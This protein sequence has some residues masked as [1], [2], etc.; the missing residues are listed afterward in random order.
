MMDGKFLG[1]YTRWGTVD[2]VAASSRFTA[3]F[4][5]GATFEYIDL[6][7][8]GTTI[9]QVTNISVRING[10]EIQSFR[11]GTELELWNSFQDEDYTTVAG[12][13]RFDFRR[14]GT[15]N[16]ALRD[17]TMIGT[18]VAAQSAAQAVVSTFEISGDLASGITPTITPYASVRDAAPLGLLRLVRP[19]QFTPPAT[20]SYEWDGLP[21]SAVIE[22]IGHNM[23][24]GVFD[25]VKLKVNQNIISEGPITRH[26][27]EQNNGVRRTQSNWFF[28]EPDPYGDGNDLYNMSGVADFRLVYN[29]TTANP[30]PVVASYLG[31]L[32]Q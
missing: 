1:M 4:Q 2:G 16:P 29:V 21:R 13:L 22:R 10:I 23:G 19:F 5:P 30:I 11:S 7:M 9:A 27:A 18:G 12:T 28:V 8:T 17:Q 3:R 32:G 6:V 26:N 15:K 20:G 31:F 24:S 25:E 14:L